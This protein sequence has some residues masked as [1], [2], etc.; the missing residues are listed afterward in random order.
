MIKILS[1]LSSVG[2]LTTTSTAVSQEQTASVMSMKA[3]LEQEPA[4]PSF[5]YELGLTYIKKI[6][7]SNSSV[8]T[9]PEN[10]SR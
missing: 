3:T 10:S 1:I 8:R 4:N 5:L 6:S 9:I 7:T 2:L